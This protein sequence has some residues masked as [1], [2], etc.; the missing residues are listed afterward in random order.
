MK[1]IE[2]TLAFECEV[3]GETSRADLVAR[4]L[5]NLGLRSGH[6]FYVG[7]ERVTV[8]KIVLSRVSEQ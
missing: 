3:E 8:E 2:V 7:H 4:L 5:S 1:R 6:Y